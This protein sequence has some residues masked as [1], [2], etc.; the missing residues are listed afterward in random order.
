MFYYNFIICSVYL[1]V[2][3]NWL[4]FWYCLPDNS[5]G[6]SNHNSIHMFVAE[7]SQLF[8]FHFD[9]S[10]KKLQIDQLASYL[11]SDKCGLYGILFLLP[12]SFALGEN[13]ISR[14]GIFVISRIGHFK[15]I[16]QAVDI[17]FHSDWSEMSFFSPPFNI[18]IKYKFYGPNQEDFLLNFWFDIS[19][20]CMFLWWF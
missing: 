10:T 3:I 13:I 19:Y 15:S 18:F 16:G 14:K 17:I 2:M 12:T 11:N 20:R 9:L 1:C 8:L 4:T 6:D 5:I 7:V